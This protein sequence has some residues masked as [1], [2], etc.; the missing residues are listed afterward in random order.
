MASDRTTADSVLK[1]FYLDPARDIL[2]SKVFLLSQVEHNSEDIEGRRAV[3]SINTGRNQGVGA[4]AEGGTLPTAGNQAFSEER[5]G[6]KYNYG[7]I[8]LSGPVMRS[9]KSQRGSFLRAID[10]E[11]KGVVR[12]LRNDVN[13]QL[14]G[15]SDGMIVTLGASGATN[16]GTVQNPTPTKM[17]QLQVNMAIDIGTSANP[18]ATATNRVIT[19]VNATAGSFVF[20][21]AAVAITAADRVTRFGSGGTGVAQKELTGLQTQ[22]AASGTLWNV[23]PTLAPDWAS[24]VDANAGV[25]RPVAEAMFTKAEMEVNIRSGET[26][27]LW[28]TSDGVLRAVSALLTSLKRFPGTVKLE[29][30]FR[31]ID[32]SSPTQGEGGE[33]D[34]GM[35]FEKDCPTN[36]AF[37]LTTKRLQWYMMS[38]WEFM[39]EDGALFSRVPNTDAYEATLFCYSELAT[40]GRNAHARVTDLTPA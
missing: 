1:E 14:Y 26:P 23:D 5:V 37:L 12:D 29:G 39:E 40:D 28:V 34:V 15:V 18:V 22:V 31:G 38:D 19:S 27:K 7:R 30:G 9:T 13:R 24:Y 20:N 33:N 2:N 17:R 35:V 11:T 3:L 10:A 8:Q 16:T 6:L 4:R 21:G 36:D 32:V 25:N